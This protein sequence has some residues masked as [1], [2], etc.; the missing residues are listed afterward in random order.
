[1]FAGFSLDPEYGL[2]RSMYRPVELFIG[3][4][5]T[6][7]KRRNHFISFI[8][9]FSILGI[10]LGVA[11]LITVMS[12]MNGFQKELRERVLGMASHVT[13]SGLERTLKDWPGLIEQARTHPE[14]L[15]AAPYINGEGMLT[16][17]QF[18]NGV[19]VRGVL[20]KMEAEV[21]NVGD[22]MIV[23]SM[24]DLVP[25]DFRI[26]LGR[27]L[28]RSLG[29]DIGDKVTLVS[30]QA[31]V[32]PAGILPRLKRFTV[33]GIFEVGHNE[34]DSSFALIHLEDAARIFRMNDGISGFRLKLQDIFA[35]PRVGR[36][37]AQTMKGGFIVNDW[38][39]I[40]ANFFKAIQMEKRVMFVI[41]TLI[42]AVAAFNI[43]S[44]MVMVVTDKQSDIA[45]L[46]TLGA[47]SSNIMNIFII[48]GA[49]IGFVGTLF[50]VLGGIILAANIET[51]VP[52]I[53]TVFGFKFL[54]ADVYLISEVPSDLQIDDI[55]MVSVVAFALTLL[56]TLYP[57]WRGAR[58]QPAEALRYE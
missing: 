54:S 57:A 37:L 6:R 27:Y 53:E 44:T 9:L 43:V 49:V 47:S 7:S 2:M 16:H 42:I 8:S 56:A 30:P 3:L 32:T 20:P 12:V 34:Y 25:G 39:R 52:L 14:V 21:S 17:G 10:T 24:D 48:Q 58:V 41:L 35:A 31:Q 1:M 38:T 13:I 46:R 28:A 55:T 5:Y 19:L 4:R 11:V 26:I 15:G 50:G 45:I 36:E 23:G 29:A 18:V 22:K 40:H 51:I 33:V